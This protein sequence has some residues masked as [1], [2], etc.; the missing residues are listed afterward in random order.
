VYTSSKSIGFIIACVATGA[1]SFP[2]RFVTA[3]NDQL[4]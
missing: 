2:K 3:D 1:A 4:S